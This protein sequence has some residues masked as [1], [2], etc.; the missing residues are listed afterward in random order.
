MDALLVTGLIAAL[1]ALRRRKGGSMAVP[2]MKALREAVLVGAD[3]IDANLSGFD[4]SRALM[5]WVDLTGANLAGANLSG[6]DLTAANLKGATYDDE[7][8][9]PGGFDPDGRGMVKV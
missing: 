7:T 6:T 3:L 2:R 5:S 4:L 9:L 1:G 8:M